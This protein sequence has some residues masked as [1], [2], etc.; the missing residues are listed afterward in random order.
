MWEPTGFVSHFT[1][2]DLNPGQ[3]AL[4]DVLEVNSSDDLEQLEL[5]AETLPNVVLHW[6]VP[7]V[8]SLSIINLV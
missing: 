6:E 5:E 4:S 3:V 8:R 2:S 1:E 7:N